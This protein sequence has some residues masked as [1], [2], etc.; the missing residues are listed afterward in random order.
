MIKSFQE[1]LDMV[2][3]SLPYYLSIV[4][5]LVET[6][7]FPDSDVEFL[8]ISL[9]NY[10]DDSIPYDKII[11]RKGTWIFHYHTQSTAGEILC[12]EYDVTPVPRNN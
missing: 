11:F 3:Q 9:D 10:Y 8:L 7:Q 5:T 4:H 6:K 2:Y 1:R 12:N